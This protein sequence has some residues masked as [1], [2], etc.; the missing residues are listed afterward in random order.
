LLLWFWRR[1]T[2]RITG[3]RWQNLRN[4]SLFLVLFVL[5][6]LIIVFFIDLL[7]LNL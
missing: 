2:R 7:C 1:S 3:A 5:E 6:I 4:I